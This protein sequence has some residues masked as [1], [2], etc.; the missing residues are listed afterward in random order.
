MNYVGWLLTIHLLGAALWVGGIGFLLL[1]LRPSVAVL[2][3]SARL[4]LHAQVFARFFRMLWHVV[5]LV[6]ATG[7]AVLFGFYGGF[8]GV[9]WPVHLMHLTGLMMTLLFLIIFFVPFRALR[10]AAADANLAV[11]V[12]AM[13]RLRM[14]ASINLALGIVTLAAAAFAA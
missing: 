7:Y 11:G 3:P 14:L 12:A 4:A 8:K 13:A 2:E 1:I 9:S 10:L 5:P 6:L